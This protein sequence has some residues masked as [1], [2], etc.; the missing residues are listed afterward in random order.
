MGED[1]LDP[2]SL[3]PFALDQ[4]VLDHTRHLNAAD[5]SGLQQL[6]SDVTE[7]DGVRPLSEH[8]W[9]HVVHGGDEGAEHLLVRDPGLSIVGYAHLDTTDQVEGPSAELAVHPDF[10]QRGIGHHIVRQL[11]ALS[12][13]RLRLW[14]HG[15]NSA[16]ARLAESLGFERHR[17]LW[18]MRRSLHSS[19]PEP[20]FPTGISVEPFVVGRDDDA[21][22]A[23][24]ACAFADLPD[25]GSWELEDLRRRQGEDWFDPGGFLMAWH[26]DPA[27]PNTAPTLAGFHWTKIHG[28]HHH[29]GRQGSQGHP[30]GSN[31]PGDHDGHSHGVIGEVYVLAVSPT[32]RGSGL[33]RALTLAGLHHLRRVGLDQVMLY[34]DAAN[35]SAIRLY[36][37]LGFVRWD[38][39]V[40]FRT[41]ID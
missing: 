11:L 22:L 14:A 25:Q 6:L 16:A 32:W 21:F 3:D 13:G 31:G 34:V 33:G 9:L 36:E 4:F 10:R 7:A 5:V 15:E 2:F 17:V 37:G 19:I 28:R 18:Q 41:R 1:S 29:P 24:N 12:G 8:V 40:M 30:Q 38:T 35:V 23:L 39:D 26:R 27:S 20:Q